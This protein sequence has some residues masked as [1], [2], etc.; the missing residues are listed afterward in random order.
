MFQA[1]AAQLQPTGF[2]NIGNDTGSSVLMHRIRAHYDLI[3]AVRTFNADGF[4][5]AA[6]SSC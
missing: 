1:E 5:V 3:H 2:E 6:A 4:C